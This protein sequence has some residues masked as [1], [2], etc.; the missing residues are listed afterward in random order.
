MARPK[1]VDEDQLVAVPLGKRSNSFKDLTGQKFGRLTVLSFAGIDPVK[2]RAVYNVKCDCGNCFVALAKVLT[3]GTTRSCGCLHTDSMSRHGL[4]KTKLYEHWEGIKARC[5]NTN[6]PAYHNYGGRGITL[7]AEW[8]D[9]PAA[10]ID[11]IK[12]NLGPK[13]TKMHTL[14]RIDNN[15]NY[16]PGNL[17]WADR[18]VQNYNRR[19]S[20]GYTKTPTHQ[21]WVT[22]NYNNKGDVCSR[23]NTSKGGSFENFLVDM[24]IKPDGSKLYRIDKSQPYSPT[25][26]EW[27]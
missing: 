15:G 3:R 10:F 12:S 9:D 4:H 16:E 7:Y 24:G 25:N 17:R 13:P 23:W 21:A 2:H 20:H 1:I 14:D 8:V 22:M 6:N 19:V 5:F 11:W 26:C 18:L 27:R